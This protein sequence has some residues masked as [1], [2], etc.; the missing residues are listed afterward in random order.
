MFQGICKGVSRKIETLSGDS[1]ETQ[2]Y[3]KV[4]RVL[5]GSFKGVS[6]MF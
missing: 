6:K 3:L 5:Q 4:Q 2:G 1:R